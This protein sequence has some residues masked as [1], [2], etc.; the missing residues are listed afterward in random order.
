MIAC[1]TGEACG[2]TD[3]RSC[4]RK[5]RNQSVVMIDTIDALDVWWPPT[6]T[7]S[8]LGRTRFASCTIAVAS[9]STRRSMSCKAPKVSVS[10][11]GRPAAILI[12]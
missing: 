7:P 4:E 8:R 6:L 9:H 12:V 11:S 3:T 10:A 5:W 2:F 1:S